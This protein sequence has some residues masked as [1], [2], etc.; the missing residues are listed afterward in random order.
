MRHELIRKDD[1]VHV[2]ECGTTTNEITNTSS[3]YPPTL[4][5]LPTKARPSMSDEPVVTIPPNV[6]LPSPSVAYFSSSQGFS[7]TGSTKNCPSIADVLSQLYPEWMCAP[8]PVVV[9]V[10]FV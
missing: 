8:Q 7:V 2:G 9:I 10:V 3:I 4:I 5:Y 1:S 6:A